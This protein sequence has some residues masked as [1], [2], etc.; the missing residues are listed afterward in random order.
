MKK[1][2]RIGLDIANDVVINIFLTINSFDP[3]FISQYKNQQK[4]R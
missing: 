2:Y 1:V 4:P 3:S